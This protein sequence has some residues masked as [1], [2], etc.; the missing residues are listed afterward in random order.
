MEMRRGQFSRG[1]MATLLLS[2]SF[3]ARE[4][5]ALPDADMEGMPP[6]GHVAAAGQRPF[7]D[8][9]PIIDRKPFGELVKISP[10]K[11]KVEEAAAVEQEKQEQKLAR[12]IDL[13][14]VNIT[15][16]GQ[17][18]V[19]FVDK[20]ERPP[21][22]YYVKLGDTVAGYTIAYAD[23]DEEIA[24]IEKDDVT[25]SLKLGQGLIKSTNTPSLKTANQ[26]PRPSAHVAANPPVVNRPAKVTTTH[27][28][29]ATNSPL[30]ASYL[31]RLR[32]KREERNR[33]KSAEITQLREEIGKI[34][35]SSEE[36][37]KK[38]ER[39]INLELISRGQQPLSEI[40]LT[41]EE[42]AELVRKG[43]LTEQ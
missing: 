32:A 14:A 11:S 23:V 2:C 35:Q 7:S 30:R 18:A 1:L 9:Q 4:L 37:A 19:G 40:Q 12:Q 21:R 20:S 24:T 38:R 5:P 25:I 31:Q 17:I 33:A 42:D 6:A 28:R 3:F 39:A 15:P 43:V 27:F 13:K 22:T 29:A 10:A 8:Y 41:P 36:A 16:R 34:A 26:A